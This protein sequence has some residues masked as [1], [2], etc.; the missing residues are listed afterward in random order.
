LLACP[1]DEPFAK[2]YDIAGNKLEPE[3]KLSATVETKSSLKDDPEH[4]KVNEA[5]IVIWYYS[6]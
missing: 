1:A 6:H 4:E 3:E 2:E 5:E